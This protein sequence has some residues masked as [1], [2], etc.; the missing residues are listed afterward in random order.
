M[1]SLRF[2][3]EFREEL[4]TLKGHVNH[5][6][7]SSL[8][9]GYSLAGTLKYIPF[10]M[11]LFV[12]DTPLP[13]RHSLATMTSSFTV[14]FAPIKQCSSIITPQNDGA[15]RNETVIFQYCMVSNNSARSDKNIA[16]NLNTWSDNSVF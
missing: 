1:C 4:D 3:S 16:T 12:I 6:L 5:V 14:A 7:N 11:V 8:R 10:S 15:R 9:L 2:Y 13:I